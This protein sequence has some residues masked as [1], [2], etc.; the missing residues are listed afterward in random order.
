MHPEY[1]WVFVNSCLLEPRTLR[2]QGLVYVSELCTCSMVTAHPLVT[3]DL[4]FISE[5]ACVRCFI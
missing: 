1:F 5:F 4:H 3:S 2:Y